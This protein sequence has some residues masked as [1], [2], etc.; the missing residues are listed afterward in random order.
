MSPRTAS[1][2]DRLWAQVDKSGPCWQWTGEK[3]RGGYG[4]MSIKGVRR[5]V[6]RIAWEMQMGAIPEG[7]LLDHTCHNKA[8]VNVGHLRLATT[9]Q[10]AENR[11]GPPSNSTNGSLGVAFSKR[12]GKYEGR[13]GH[14]GTRFFAGYHE[15]AEK[16]A[17][18]A[19]Q[20]RLSLFTHNDADRK[21][22]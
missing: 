2:Q 5:A 14:D 9:K 1:V 4:R 22:A 10:N 11:S 12:R 17:E 21:S 19:R 13:V 3:G 20:L 7:M 18:A 15:T 16:A 6:H 8:C